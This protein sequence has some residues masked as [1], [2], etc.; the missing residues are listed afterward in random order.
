MP[1][2]SIVLPI[3][4]VEKYL[5]RALDSLKNQTLNDLEFICV[6]D[7]SIDNSLEILKEYA[8]Q[9]SRFVIIS[10]KNQGAGVARNT[11]LKN[12]KGKYIAFLDPDDWLELNAMEELYKSAEENNASVVLFSY[13][14]A[15]DINKIQASTAD[16]IL[17]GCGFDLYK[18]PNFHPQDLKD[19]LL[20]KA[21][22]C[23]WDKF[24]LKEFLE[25]NSINFPSTYNGQDGLF[26]LKVY[27][28]ADTI[29]YLDKYLY[30]YYMRSN[31]AVNKFSVRTFSGFESYEVVKEF[32]IKYMPEQLEN[33]VKLSIRNFYSLY[34]LIPF[35]D[36]KNR[37]KYLQRAKKFFG[38]ENY[39]KFL[40][41]IKRNQ[42]YLI[43]RIFSFS[44]IYKN[45]LKYKRLTL[46]GINWD[47][48]RKMRNVK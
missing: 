38:D 31:S 12:S 15:S 40:S 46:L 36:Y 22:S 18:T 43:S 11:G 32:I 39:K 1:K 20:S 33:F 16:N 2:V 41:Y 44:K 45:G 27:Y 29:Y 47:F 35:Y 7:G 26:S 4:N 23:I 42:P 28:Y 14:I 5:K 48:E 9:D 34:L 24:Y 25:K 37:K 13:N 10:Q 21:C 8:K 6:D 19:H 17:Y 30:N 3:Y